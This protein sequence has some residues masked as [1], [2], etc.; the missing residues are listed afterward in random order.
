MGSTQ[1]MKAPETLTK[2][3]RE[4]AD[5]LL[6]EL[7]FKTL[8][9]TIA[10]MELPADQVKAAQLAQARGFLLDNEVSQQTLNPMKA[11]EA[12]SGMYRNLEDSLPAP[13]ELDS[14]TGR[15]SSEKQ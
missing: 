7:W 12:M 10:V 11:Q 1:S 13:E 15:M 5:K 6:T 2:D 14:I 3:E 9:T 8:K 4:Q